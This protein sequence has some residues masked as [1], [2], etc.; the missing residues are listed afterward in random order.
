MASF[1]S[2]FSLYGLIVPW[3]L[4]LR[5]LSSGSGEVGDTLPSQMIAEC[6][7]S[8]WKCHPAWNRIAQEEVK[9]VDFLH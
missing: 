1:L 7:S 4:G 6:V 5:G 2:Y 8:R 3:C 9:I